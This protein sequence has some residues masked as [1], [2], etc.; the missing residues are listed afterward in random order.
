MS[1]C[2]STPCACHIVPM[3]I[4]TA[5]AWQLLLC[6]VRDL[7]RRIGQLQLLLLLLLLLQM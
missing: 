1:P 7:P 2:C 5:G 4:L 3:L 6:S